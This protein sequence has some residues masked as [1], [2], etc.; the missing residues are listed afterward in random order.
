MRYTIYENE[1]KKHREERLDACADFL[2]DNI[3]DFKNDP[4]V[5]F[6][7]KKQMKL[8][9]SCGKGRFI[10]ETVKLNPDV[11]FISV[12]KNANVLVLAVEKAKNEKLTNVKFVRGGG[13]VKFFLN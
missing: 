8:E 13:R 1:K 5:F 7:T 11:N 4:S 2:I 12:E 3:E 6:E 10:T 9:I